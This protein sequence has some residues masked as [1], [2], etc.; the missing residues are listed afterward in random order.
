MNFVNGLLVTLGALASIAVGALMLLAVTDVLAP[1][2]AP[3]PLLREQLAVM[4][5]DTGGAWWRNVGISLGF[6]ALGLAL[7]ALE[8][9]GLTRAATPNMVL[10][11]SEAA[12]TVRMSVE[13]IVQLS[14]RTAQVNREVRSV[15]CH[16]RAT[17]GGLV[18]QCTAS[19]RMGADVPAVAADV[20][21]NIREVVERL[22][23]LTVIDVPVR[24]RYQ[25]D[26]DQPVLT[27]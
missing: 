17:P 23:S 7:L 4:A 8:A 27:R 5:E 22:T 19:L 13:S 20:Q 11:S 26:R 24:A 18:I 25:G 21:S 16:V 2:S 9:R 1:A 14:Q 10:V 15:R 12:G 6:I 3:I